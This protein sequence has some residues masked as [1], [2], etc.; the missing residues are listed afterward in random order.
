M[1]WVERTS[2]GGEVDHG[3]VVVVGE[4]EDTDTACTCSA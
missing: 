2:A 3:D 4:R 1:R